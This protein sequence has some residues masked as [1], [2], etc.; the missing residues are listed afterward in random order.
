MMLSMTERPDK[1]EADTGT[2]GHW[3]HGDRRPLAA[4]PTRR[5]APSPHRPRWYWLYFALAAFDLLT[6]SFSL[7]LNHRLMTIYTESVRVNQEWADRLNRYSEIARLAA[8]VNAPGKDVFDSQDMDAESKRLAV[9]LATF[10]QAFAEARDDLTANVTPT[11]AGLLLDDLERIRLAMNEM[12]AEAELIFAYF[13]SDRPR[14]AGERMATMDRK[15]AQVN[16]ALTGLNRHVREIQ[17]TLFAEQQTAA[18]ALRRF[19]YIIAGGIVVMILAVMFYGHI[20][21]RAVMSAEKEREQYVMALR[22]AHDKLEKRVAERT[23]E[24]SRANDVLIQEI[25]E[26]K[27][28]EE[29]LKNSREHLRNLA[30][31]LQSVREEERTRIA[32]EIH[33]ELGQTLTGLKMDLS[34]LGSKLSEDGGDVLRALLLEKINAMSKLINATIQEV[35]KIATELRPGVLDDLGLTAAIEWQ[36]Q[37]FQTRTG[38]Q[39]MVTLPPEDVTLDQERSTAIFRIFQEILTNVARHANATTVNSRLTA[40]A[41]HLILEVSDNGQGITESE[42]SGSKSLGLL[43]MRERAL[44]LGGEVHIRGIQGKGTTVMVRLPLPST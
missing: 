5:V 41:G 24:L 6:V 13:R 36:A 2:R 33:D 22:E 20:M 21:A 11:K 40:D 3:R 32:R 44:L 37:E 16:M 28:A 14:E 23:A 1:Q 35:R 10:N 39:C 7:Y 43:G 4:S 34:W 18:S 12:T 31:H 38:L 42:I 26:R 8:A 25:A 30:A 27:R 17:K 15:Y 9:A 29:Q 19:E